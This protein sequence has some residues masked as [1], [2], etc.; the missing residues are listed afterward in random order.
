[1]RANDD[2]Q[3]NLLCYGNVCQPKASILF[4]A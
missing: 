1:M 2:I 4:S 3:D